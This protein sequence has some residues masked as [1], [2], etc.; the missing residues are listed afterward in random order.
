[1]CTYPGPYLVGEFRLQPRHSVKKFLAHENLQ[2]LKLVH[3]DTT[4]ICRVVRVILLTTFQHAR[5]VLTIVCKLCDNVQRQITI[6]IKY[7]GLIG[8]NQPF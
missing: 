6:S 1:M 5:P 4:Y 8:I 3:T 7:I 2:Y